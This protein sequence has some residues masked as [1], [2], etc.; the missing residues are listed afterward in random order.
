[1]TDSSYRWV[2]VGYT[3][4]IQAVCLGILVYCFPLFAVSWLDEFDV[5][6][7]EVM[8]TISLFQVASGVFSPFA[9]R[10]MDRYP[11]RSIIL[12]GMLLLCVGLFLASRA[13]ALW[14]V[15]V[16]YSTLMPFS[17]TLMSTLASQ[18]LITR[19]FT[20][21]RGLA[22]GLS[23][24][25]TNLGGIL[26]PLFVVG[27]LVDP[28]WRDVMF[29][30]A[31][32]SVVLVGPATWLILRRSPPALV[33]T[34]NNAIDGRSWTTSEILSTRMFWIPLLCLLPLNISFGAIIFNLGAYAK[35]LGFDTETTGTLLALVSVCMILGKFFFGGLGDRLDHRKLYWV[36]AC[37]M[38]M[39]TVLIQNHPGFG[40]LAAGVICVGLAGGGI[41][42]LLGLIFG[43]RF[44]VVSFGR[45]MGL[46]MLSISFGSIG[47]FI[48]G[49]IYDMT[50]S[51]DT[52]F[53]MFGLAFVPAI[54]A[55]RWL[56]EPGK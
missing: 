5:S 34:N 36:A 20:N 4:I 40:L 30:L 12:F 35:D 43:T 47:P 48:A 19:W 10:A 9:G 50:G 14:Q 26:F 46:A 27:W 2:I 53:T 33:S 16:L 3:L 6:R 1:M 44:G 38:M 31:V 15:Q 21:N 42:P 24:T 41:L 17:V 29:G 13:T 37:F 11:I 54:I 28:G 22:I 51:Y 18:I 39:A 25:G 23:A 49:W 55:M 32:T 52:A 8:L 56:P 45:V 7:G